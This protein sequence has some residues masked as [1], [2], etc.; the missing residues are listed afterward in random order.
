MDSGC[1]GIPNDAP[2]SI[3]GPVGTWGACVSGLMPFVSTPLQLLF[4]RSY[5]TELLQG[6]QKVSGAPLP[7]ICNNRS[8]VRTFPPSSRVS[9]GSPCVRGARAL[10]QLR[11]GKGERALA[12][13]SSPGFNKGLHLQNCVALGLQP[14]LWETRFSHL[15]KTKQNKTGLIIEVWIK[16]GNE[17]GGTL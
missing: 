4:I 14:N 12:S 5:W 13:E 11:K 16:L 9:K 10:A 1:L 8:P 7:A 6:T 17:A 2:D 15:K 3:G